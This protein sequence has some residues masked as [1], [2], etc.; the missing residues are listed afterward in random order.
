MPDV[1]LPDGTIVQN[2]PDTPEARAQLAAAW[3]SRQAAQAKAA[4]ASAPASA[5]D[6]GAD[7]S[8]GHSLK[9]GA[10]ALARGLASGP[11]LVI[12]GLLSG[13][14]P[15]G[16]GE[17]EE[18]PF[19]VSSQVSSLGTQPKTQGER[20]ANAAIEG[21]AGAALPPGGSIVRRAVVGAGSGAGGE[22]GTQV[23]GDHWWSRLLGNLLGG[24]TTGL[25][26]SVRTTRPEIV[27]EATAG[28]NPA[29]LET[30]RANM[31]KFL[32]A[33]GKSAVNASQ[34]MP[35]PSPIDAMV[36]VLA[37]SR[38]GTNVQAQL[39]AQ[40]GMAAAETTR[41]IG[42]LPG[43]PGM[44]QEVANSAQQAATSA[45]DA[46]KKQRTE[47]WNKTVADNTPVVA[48]EVK[49]ELA[50]ATAAWNKAFPGVDPTSVT[51]A[52]LKHGAGPLLQRVLSAQAANGQVPPDVVRAEIKRLQGLASETPNTELRDSLNGL[53]KQLTLPGN[54]VLTD[55][56]KINKALVDYSEAL[57]RPTLSTPGAQGGTQ[58]FVGA[59][60]SAVKQNL[61]DAMAPI[62][63]A[64]QIYSNM[65]DAVVNPAKQSIVGSVAGTTGFDPAKNAVA[66][67]LYAVFDKG[68]TPGAK[69]S[70]ILELEKSMR[71]QPGG[72]QAFQ[73][74]FKTWVTQKTAPPLDAKG[75]PIAEDY[76][77]AMQRVFGDPTK[78]TPA[79]QG[80]KDML[81]A[82][83]RSQGKPDA[84]YLQGFEN[85]Q[86]FLAMT[87]KRPNRVG[88]STQDFVQAGAGGGQ[89][90]LRDNMASALFGIRRALSNARSGDAQRF[91][92]RLLTTPEGMDVLIKMAKNPP[93]S[94]ASIT[95]LSTFLGAA[96]TSGPITQQ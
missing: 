48:P 14:S 35:A 27:K 88:P 2:V 54:A 82:L 5:A 4:P 17:S 6:A 92:D 69:T 57:K 86:Q 96:P 23:A 31:A 49:Q 41:R 30:A 68:T 85:L 16:M 47:V 71:G 95:A 19:P 7:T 52:Q 55:P 12:D 89:E 33:D 78:A 64:D 1:K 65:T 28:V 22:A 36:D 15:K 46:L 20:Y 24:G 50:D 3:Q 60:I 76:S 75:L 91:M 93:M 94:Q 72:P 79:S 39:N 34:A 87:A 70:D 74:A 38:N 44:P 77:A 29:D 13:F 63:L 51:S 90:G 73:D 53:A 83:A 26:T 56:I 59:Q 32:T 42:L 18:P 66:S 25:V 11:A 80:T 58:K 45:I 37:N 21:A 81:V 62:R 43:T 9:L 40:P 8:F 61:G 84:T 10:S 67:R